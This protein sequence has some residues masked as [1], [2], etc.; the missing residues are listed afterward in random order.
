MDADQQPPG[1]H[2]SRQVA[3]A[4]PATPRLSQRRGSPG[5]SRPPPPCRREP[6]GV[7]P[8]GPRAAAP[9]PRR[10]CARSAGSTGRRR[11]EAPP[12][13]FPTAPTWKSAA[14]AVPACRSEHRR[15]LRRRPD[16]ERPLATVGVRIQ[17][18]SEAALGGRELAQQEVGRSPAPPAR[19]AAPRSAATSPGSTSSSSA[20]SYSIFSKC[21]TAH[22]PSTLYRA[23]PPPS[24]S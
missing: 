2:R 19:P 4:P 12:S 10:Y 15:D 13:T 23:K 5:R 14:V 24:W 22:S 9:P 18:R 20:L 17:R 3:L 16:I 1:G 11:V 21:G 8:P 7:E 6:A